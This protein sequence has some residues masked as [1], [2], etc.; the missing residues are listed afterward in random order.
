MAQRTNNFARVYYGLQ[1]VRV[2]AKPNGCP[3]SSYSGGVSSLFQSVGVNASTEFEQIYELGRAGIYTNVEG[4]PT[5]EITV[6]RA[7][8]SETFGALWYQGSTTSVSDIGSTLFK[9][10]MGISPETNCGVLPASGFVVVDNAVM[11]NYT[12]NF[13]LDGPLTESAT[14]EANNISWTEGNNT[15]Y[16]D[17]NETIL[18]L[19]NNPSGVVL[20][21]AN[22]MGGGPMAGELQSASFSISIDREDILSLGNRFPVMRPVSFPVEATAEFEYLVGSSGSTYGL[23]FN[24]NNDDETNFAGPGVPGGI[25]GNI[26]VTSVHLGVVSGVNDNP[27]WIALMYPYLTSSSYSGGDA[28]GGNAT[29]THTFTGY[30]GIAF[31]TG[32]NVFA[33]PLTESLL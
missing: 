18:H 22:V 5:A 8:T 23:A 29:I 4:I 16:S 3:E 17:L 28:G 6:E 19:N 33:Q 14:Y 9:I 15:L 24:A 12:M 7:M 11:T 25:K 1:T 20:T 31:G 26:N 13:N 2:Q 32:P 21:R 30:D 27:T 10:T